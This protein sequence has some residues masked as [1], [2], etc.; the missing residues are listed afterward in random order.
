[1]VEN[2][3]LFTVIAALIEPELEDNDQY[4]K[5]KGRTVCDYYG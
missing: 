5:E 2:D 4:H 1:M 3:S